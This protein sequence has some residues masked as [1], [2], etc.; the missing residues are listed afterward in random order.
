MLF[1]NTAS[2]AC[3]PAIDYCDSCASYR[4]DLQSFIGWAQGKFYSGGPFDNDYYSTHYIDGVYYEARNHA[5][6]TIS[7]TPLSIESRDGNEVQLSYE[8]TVV[9]QLD[10][11]TIDGELNESFYYDSTS[12]GGLTV[13]EFQYNCAGDTPPP[14]IIPP[15]PPPNDPPDDHLDDNCGSDYE[16]C[17][18]QCSENKCLT[19][20]T[21][22]FCERELNP[23]TGMPTN[24]DYDDNGDF[25]DDQTGQSYWFDGENEYVWDEDYEEWTLYNQDYECSIATLLYC[26]DQNSHFMSQFSCPPLTCTCISSSEWQPVVD[27]KNAQTAT[28]ITSYEELN[29]I[30][31]KQQ[32]RK[33]STTNVLDSLKESNETLKLAFFNR[34]TKGGDGDT[35]NFDNQ[36]GTTL[37]KLDQIIINQEKL[38]DIELQPKKQNQELSDSFFQRLQSTPIFQA[39]R[40]FNVGGQCGF[41]DHEINFFG[42]TYNADFKIICDLSPSY[43][44]GIDLITMLMYSLISVRAFMRA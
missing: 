42:T 33:S 17:K 10:E 27:A 25:Y 36:I 20:T 35:S 24:L 13:T 7:Y 6:G 21:N 43:E 3:S 31:L 28:R 4:G 11:Y 8:V 37:T 32:Q 2:K 1:T 5:F 9:S 34:K 39:S 19:F 22:E 18:V 40:S 12:D 29:E 14:P 30:I 38:A 41:G 26:N 15:P 44:N 16:S 23:Y